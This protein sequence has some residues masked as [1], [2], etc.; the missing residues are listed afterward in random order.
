MCWFSTLFVQFLQA[1]NPVIHKWQSLSYIFQRRL[2]H[3]RMIAARNIGPQDSSE[4]AT[5]I[6]QL[7]TFFTLHRQSKDNGTITISGNMFLLL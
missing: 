5:D 6:A 4:N 3:L 1:V 2:R 7:E